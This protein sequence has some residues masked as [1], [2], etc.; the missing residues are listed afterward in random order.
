MSNYTEIFDSMI[1]TLSQFAQSEKPLCAKEV[2]HR[3]DIGLR[4]AQRIMK[5]L[6]ESGWLDSTRSGKSKLYF[7]TDKTKQLFGVQG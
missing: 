1:F 7:A 2:A 5:S 3:L 4:T 6:Y